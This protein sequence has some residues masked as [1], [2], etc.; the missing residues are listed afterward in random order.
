MLYVENAS[1]MVMC[2]EK[3]ENICILEAFT[4]VLVL[5]SL[6]CGARHTELRAALQPFWHKLDIDGSGASGWS[7]LGDLL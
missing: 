2:S 1:E 4:C 7:T 5:M 3:T 6:Q